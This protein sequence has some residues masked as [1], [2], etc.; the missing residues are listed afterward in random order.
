MV[1]YASISPSAGITK[2][3]Y[4][5]KNSEG[6]DVAYSP[7]RI[8]L[9]QNVSN[10]TLSNL[11]SS[12]FKYGTGLVSNRTLTTGITFNEFNYRW[13]KYLW[14]GPFPCYLDGLTT[15]G[16]QATANSTTIK[17]N[18]KYPIYECP[19]ATTSTGGWQKSFQ[20]ELLES[21][22]IFVQDFDNSIEG[23]TKLPDNQYW[24]CTIGNTTV[25][26]RGCIFDYEYAYS[27]DRPGDNDGGPGLFQLTFAQT[28]DKWRY[29]TAKAVYKGV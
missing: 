11:F 10:N 5:Y 22:G 26:L 8:T 2:I 15:N 16:Q 24:D 7:N 19:F 18:G 6:K 4:S 29:A 27:S 28:N 17:V 13:E 21:Q 14:G 1:E 12:D 20:K 9:F 23:T 3:P 25:G